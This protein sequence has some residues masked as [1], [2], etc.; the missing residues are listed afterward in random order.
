MYVI[1]EILQPGNWTIWEVEIENVR[2]ETRKLYRETRNCFEERMQSPIAQRFRR[3]NL[4][5]KVRENGKFNAR[6]TTRS[7][8]SQVDVRMQV[9]W[10]KCKR[11]AETIAD[12]RAWIIRLNTQGNKTFLQVI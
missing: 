6:E 8:E 3:G 12:S 7:H 2:S 10:R 5:R 11:F 4:Y 1:S 9:P